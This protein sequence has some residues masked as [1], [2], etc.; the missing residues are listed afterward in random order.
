VTPREAPAPGRAAA[1]LNVAGRELGAIFDSSVAYV[2]AI[3]FLLLACSTFMSDFFLA[4]QVDMSSFFETAPLLLPFFVAA[5]TMRLWA[6]ERR[7]HTDELLLTLPIRPGEAVLGKFLAALALYAVLLLGTLP[8][9][10]ML[11]ALGDPDPGLIAGGYLGLF[12]LGGLFT[13]LG[14]CLSAAVSDQISSFVL[15]SSVGLGLVLLGDPRVVAVLDGL[16]GLAPGTFLAQHVAARA[17]YEALVS[18]VLDASSLVYF[19]GLGAVLLWVNAAL[20]ARIRT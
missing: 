7:A 16:S 6:E 4:G 18:G 5:S 12:A 2:Y 13:A 8:I 9:P 11:F 19:V 14:A 17:P 15:A 3:A 1:V 10:V 20:V